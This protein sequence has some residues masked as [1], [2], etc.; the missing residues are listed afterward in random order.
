MLEHLHLQKAHAYLQYACFWE[1]SNK[2]PPI[3]VKL[4]VQMAGYYGKGT[5]D[6]LEER[7]RR[8]AGGWQVSYFISVC[9]CRSTIK[10]SRFKATAVFVLYFFFDI[11]LTLALLRRTAQWKALSFVP[12][13][14]L[15]ASHYRSIL[16]LCVRCLYK[17]GG[18]KEMFWLPL[19]S[20]Q[21]LRLIPTAVA[22][23]IW[24]RLMGV[25]LPTGAGSDSFSAF[26]LY[27]RNCQR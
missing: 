16:L 20:A 6:W 22:M 13:W 25:G 23:A 15:S 18:L 19:M 9:L 7:T 2:N 3:M 4:L 12:L 17:N 24:R 26:C 27:L 10:T 5:A 11:L 8:N 14:D 21:W 1:R